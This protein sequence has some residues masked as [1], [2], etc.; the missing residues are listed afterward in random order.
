MCAG[1]EC[2]SQRAGTSERGVEAAK[3]RVGA[4]E[5]K[6]LSAIA[7]SVH[8]GRGERGCREEVAQELKEEAEDMN[9]NMDKRDARKSI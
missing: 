5:E 4:G 3:G 6:C 7:D 1:Y 2:G 9:L 8:H